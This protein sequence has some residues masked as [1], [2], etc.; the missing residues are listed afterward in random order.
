MIGCGDVY[1]CFIGSI[2]Y[3]GIFVCYIIFD[4]WK[5]K[6]IWNIVDWLM[7]VG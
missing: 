7:C 4:S 6:I 3:F 1:I 5:V 2:D